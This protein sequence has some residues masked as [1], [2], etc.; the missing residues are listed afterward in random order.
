MHELQYFTEPSPQCEAL[1]EAPQHF[2]P[3]SSGTA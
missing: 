3:T 2:Q 1:R